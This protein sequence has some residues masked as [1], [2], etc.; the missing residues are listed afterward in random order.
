MHNKFAKRAI[1]ARHQTPI[2]AFPTFVMNLSTNMS[3]VS[4][5]FEMTTVE[6]QECKERHKRT[7]QM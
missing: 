3:H 7:K 5:Q 6:Q 4:R 1:W 2:V